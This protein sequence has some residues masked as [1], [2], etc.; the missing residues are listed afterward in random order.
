VVFRSSSRADWLALAARNLSLDS[1]LPI[2]TLCPG[3]ASSLS[4]AAHLLGHDEKAREVVGEA[5]GR[6][7]MKLRIPQVSHFLKIMVDVATMDRIKDAVSK[8]LDGLRVAC[9]YG[10]H[11]VR[12]SNA[13]DFDDPEKPVSLDNLV[14]LLGAEPIDY[15][16]K[17]MC[18]GRPSMDEATSMGIAEHKL[19]SM[20]A[21]GCDLLV[22]A[23]PFCFE[24]YDLGQVMLARKS[25]RRFDIPVVYI[26]QLMGLAMGR[27]PEEMGLDLHRTK[28]KKAL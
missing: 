9:H 13:V 10:C 2:V 24:Q 18:C 20:Q 23:C 12:P 21:A 19:S 7:G 4:E 8:N 27:T 15:E 22:V 6:T 11:L 26:T 28:L 3:C 25:E 14:A 17:Y 16:D 1:G 5:L